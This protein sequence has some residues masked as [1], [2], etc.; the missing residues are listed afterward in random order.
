MPWLQQPCQAEVSGRICLL[1]A[2]NR[3]VQRPETTLEIRGRSDDS[4][5][6]RYRSVS[7]LQTRDLCGPDSRHHFD[8]SHPFRPMIFRYQP[9]LAVYTDG[10]KSTLPRTPAPGE[11]SRETMI[12]I[13]H[14]H[15]ALNVSSIDAL[16]IGFSRENLQRG[17]CT[18]SWR[19]LSQRLRFPLVPHW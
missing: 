17:S 5:L 9:V 19:V 2:W 16:R 4:D 12:A 13:S 11:R 1:T 14:S 8:R 18:G 3:P 15:Q 10:C 6:A 7:K